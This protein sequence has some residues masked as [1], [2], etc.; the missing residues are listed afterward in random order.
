APRSTSAQ[1]AEPTHEPMFVSPHI[2]R[3]DSWLRPHF[4][5]CWRWSGAASPTN[6]ISLIVP[7]SQDLPQG[8]LSPM[9]TSLA[10]STTTNPPAQL[11]SPGAQPYSEK[12]GS[13]ADCIPHLSTS[14]RTPGAHLAAG[15]PLHPP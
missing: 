15:D 5:L 10:G 13:R 3:R 2:V 4:L 11:T 14:Q 8:S 7:G 1:P 6:P 9:T 12:R